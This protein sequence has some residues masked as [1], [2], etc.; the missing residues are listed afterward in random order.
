[1]AKFEDVYG[2]ISE[3]D[4]KAASDI[5]YGMEFLSTCIEPAIKILS[6]GIHEAV[7]NEDDA[8]EE[9]L[10]AYRRIA[11]NAK[12]QLEEY[13]N[14]FA[15]KET[16]EEV[17]DE[18]IEEEDQLVFNVKKDYSLYAVDQHKP[19]LLSE[20]Y[21]N[22]KTCAFMFKGTRYEVKDAKDMLVKLCDMLYKEDPEKFKNFDTLKKF[23]GRKLTYFG[24]TEV[25]KKNKKIPGTDIYVWTNMSCN[26]IMKFVKKILIEC[27]HKPNEFYVFIRSDFNKQ[28]EGESV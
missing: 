16:I 14:L 17:T 19:H 27:G 1:M 4:E 9:K 10:K 13:L 18:I 5:Y 20:D 24:K 11:K 21:T 22:T 28:T 26:G 15:E 6:K 8:E 3:H 7:D 12:E 2:Y 23:K 25:P